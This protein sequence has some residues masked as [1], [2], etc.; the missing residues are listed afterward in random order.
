MKVNE[1]QALLSNIPQDAEV[2]F[3]AGDD[4]S[5]NH[6]TLQDGKVKLSEITEE[7]RTARI[8]RVENVKA[9]ISW[10]AE[11][12]ENGGKFIAVLAVSIG[13]IA[14]TPLAVLLAPWTWGILNTI[15]V[16]LLPIALYGFGSGFLKA[17]KKVKELKGLIND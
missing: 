2:Q 8:Q 17:Y 16:A 5:I 7:E 1:L 12:F 13:L 15:L 10:K 9:L 4:V 14:S 11:R 3:R 6:L